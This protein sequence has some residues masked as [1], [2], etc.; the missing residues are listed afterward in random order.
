MA[1]IGRV[2]IP[3]IAHHVTQRGNNGQDVFFVDDDRRAY[4]EILG[5]QCEKY[6]LEVLGYCLMTNHLHVVA[7]PL[8]EESNIESG[9]KPTVQFSRTSPCRASTPL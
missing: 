8:R 5:L 3:G 2:V 1:R 9:S 7:K 6:G 4:L